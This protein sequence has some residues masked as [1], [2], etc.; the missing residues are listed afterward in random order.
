MSD[1]FYKL[2]PVATSQEWKTYHDIRRKILWENRGKF[3][4]YQENL[5]DEFHHQN[6]PMLL[7]YKGK[8]VGVVRIDLNPEKGPAIMRRVAI[9]V[10][11]PLSNSFV[12]NSLSPLVRRYLICVVG[13][14]IRC[15]AGASRICG[16]WH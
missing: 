5:P 6:H 11:H 2:S 12:P 16:H 3:G 13:R 1:Q 14:E 4:K 9:K 10:F 8:P 7:Y 15:R